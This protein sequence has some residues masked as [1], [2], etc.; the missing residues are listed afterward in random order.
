MLVENFELWQLWIIAGMLTVSII[1]GTSIRLL[2][3]KSKAALKGFF[4]FSLVILFLVFLGLAIGIWPGIS[5][6]NLAASLIGL[7]LGLIRVKKE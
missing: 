7:M 5:Y 2:T 6:P 4:I 3:L 1:I